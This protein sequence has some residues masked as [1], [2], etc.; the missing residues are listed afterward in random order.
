MVTKEEVKNFFQK[1]IKPKLVGLESTRKIV[2]RNLFI[3]HSIVAFLTFFVV[4]LTFFASKS[5]PDSERDFFLMIKFILPI[6]IFIDTLGHK[7]IVIGYRQQFK[8]EV[9]KELFGVL[10]EDCVY[11]PNGVVSSDFFKDSKLVTDDFNKYSGEDFVKGSIGDIEV[12]FSEIC[13]IH[14]SKT[15]EGHTHEGRKDTVF[16]GLFYVFSLKVDLK[17]NTLILNDVAESFFG[18]IIGRF[19][20]KKTYRPGYQLVQL[21]SV[22]F[23]KKFVVY[24]D[25]QVKSR[26]L[27]KPSVLE[28]LTSFK[29]KYRE[30]IEVSI[31]G[32]KLY[33]GIE[34]TRNHFEP[35][36][37]GEVVSFHEIRE[38]YD[39]IQLVRDLQEDLELESVAA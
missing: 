6:G 39:L 15:S 2:L 21:E 26:V 33:I 11:E 38:I 36:L 16:E 4:F 29:S 8:S 32:N 18:K 34:S 3:F 28:N 9:I 35:K 19:L 10:I 30:S 5:F 37:F 23:E 22:E 20:Q 1:N 12:E 14:E 13:A 17:Q 31:R 27:L 25:D 7:I 24:S